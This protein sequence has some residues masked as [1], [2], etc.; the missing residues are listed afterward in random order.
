MRE[1]D[2][3]I[4]KLKELKPILEKDYDVSEIGVFGSYVRDEQTENSDIDILV[5]FDQNAC[6]GLIKFCGMQIFLSD[7]FKK[8][9]DLVSK[10]GIKP[11]LEKYILNEVIYV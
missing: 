5:S 11:A 4:E 8:K 1:I 9:V 3:I 7:I 10:R 6:V 2:K